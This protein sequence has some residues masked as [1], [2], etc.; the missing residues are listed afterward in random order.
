MCSVEHCLP[1][2]LRTTT[3]ARLYVA[4]N[5]T[6]VIC[7]ARSDRPRIRTQAPMISHCYAK[8]AC[9]NNYVFN[10]RQRQKHYG[11]HQTARAV[12]LRNA[13]RTYSTDNIDDDD[14]DDDEHGDHHHNHYHGRML[15]WRV[16]LTRARRYN[17][18]N[19]RF[20]K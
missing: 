10:G 17:A 4:H 5:T 1:F 3:I 20:G 6:Y 11:Q 18:T 2:N 12:S 15:L 14:D 8:C 9:E 7:S 16:T 13:K 19:D